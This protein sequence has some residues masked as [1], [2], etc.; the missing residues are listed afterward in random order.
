MRRKTIAL[1]AAMFLLVNLVAGMGPFRAYAGGSGAANNRVSAGPDTVLLGDTIT[2]TATGDKQSVT[3]AV[4]LEERYIPTGWASDDG[5]SGAFGLNGGRY[6]S[7]YTPEAAGSHTVEATFQKQIWDGG[8]VDAGGET[9]TKTVEVT[10]AAAGIYEWVNVGEPGFS[11]NTALTKTSLYV[12]GDTPYVAYGDVSKG[13]KATVMKYD[14]ADW[15]AVG[16]PGF[17]EYEATTTSLYLDNGVPYVAFPNGTYPNGGSELVVMKFD[18]SWERVGDTF[19]SPGGVSSVTLVVY[20]ETPYVAYRDM[21]NGNQAAVMKYNGDDWVPVGN[22]ISGGSAAFTSLYIDE[23]TLYLAYADGSESDKV[24]VVKYDEGSDDWVPV[25]NKGFS[26]GP[27]SYNISLIVN[28]GTPYVAFTDTDR[29]N[30]ATVM[31]YDAGTDEWVALGS[32]DQYAYYLSL[33]VYNGVLNVA[34][35]DGRQNLRATVMAYNEAEDEWTAVGDPGFSPP[36]QFPVSFA[37]GGVRYLAFL[38]RDNLFKPTVMKSVLIPSEPAYAANNSVSA[39]PQEVAA[40][41]T[42]ILNA[43]GDRQ[44]AV[45][46]NARKGDERFVPTG[47]KS[48]DETTG[49]FLPSFING[50][51]AYTSSY[52]PL[53]EGTYTVKASFQKQIWNG[54]MWN[55][56]D[57]IDQKTVDITVNPPSPPEAPET[58]V[59]VGEDRSVTLYWAAV[60]RAT[61]YNV[62]M[63]TV[64]GSYDD[65]PLTTVTGATY[66][67][68]NLT[69]G[70]TYYFTV[71]AV[72]AGG[73][74]ESSPQANA[75]PSTKPGSPTQVLASAGDGQALVT[76]TA[77]ADNGGSPITGYEVT[78]SPEDVVVTGGASPITVGGLT[79]G[80]SYTFTVKAINANGPG[81]ASA[82][83]NAVIPEVSQSDDDSDDDGGSGSG[84]GNSSASPA[85]PGLPE[86][87]GSGAAGLVNGRMETVGTAVTAERNGQTVTTVTLDPQKLEERLASEGPGAVITVPVNRADVVIGTLNGQLVKLMEERQTVLEI[88]TERSTYTLPASLIN[89]DAISEQLGESVALQNIEVQ[90]EIAE[91]TAEKVQAVELT[92]ERGAFTLIAPPIEFTVR[93]T[94]GGQTMDVSKFTSY[95]ERAI[96][97]P[98]GV[99]P[100]AVTT[101]LVFHADGTVRHVPTR[102]T[103]IDGKWYAV[104]NSLTNSTYAVVGH[105]LEF[106][107]TADHWSHEAVSDMGSRMIVHGDADGLFQPDRDISRAEF[108]A[109][110]VRALGLAPE[111][112]TSPFADVQTTDWYASAVHTAYAYGLI[113]GFADGTFRPDEKITR[114]QAMVMISKAMTIAGLSAAYPAGS[115]DDALR[116]YTDAPEA[117]SWA[118]SGIADSVSAGLVLSRSEAALAPLAHI[119]RAEAVVIV[120]RLLQE[121]GLI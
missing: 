100:S 113:N 41:E 108:A 36:A 51:I 2:L 119:T 30:Q 92:A 87:A 12:D 62:Y 69:N 58:L 115:V 6:T 21:M 57:I 88:R 103:M 44:S 43:T 52:T 47:W 91:P 98:D 53:E 26:S 46:I 3:D 25:G 70:T 38:D 76:F 81:E 16:E 39:D 114:E 79:N 8:W 23:G 59:A 106:R 27:A 121:S 111:S 68:Q 42:V 107:D 83:S 50:G 29:T 77:P 37:S 4:Y 5:A 28:E 80:T 40:G 89:I 65:T 10:V 112:G 102:T 66:S 61:Q 97:I 64:N 7:A 9:D 18:G 45:G 54:S 90:I 109:I 116:A 104:V 34:Y 75:T 95:V 56:T 19:V 55:Y 110:V 60:I 17:S 49:F 82:P 11:E 86:N 48:D 118:R 73:P 78:S 93:A 67:V 96:A 33:S 85:A 15:V 1:L 74:G 72:N 117:S 31:K 14:G 24:T 63:S 101:A 20:E 22:G 94:Y 35:Q 105:P 120:R 13:G 71:K 32:G 84:S 99:D